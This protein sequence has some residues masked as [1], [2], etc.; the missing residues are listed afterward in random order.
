[1]SK[2]EDEFDN[3]IAE[4]KKALNDGGKIALKCLL[5]EIELHNYSVDDI[6]SVIKNELSGED[7]TAEKYEAEAKADHFSEEQ[8]NHE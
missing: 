4:H 5:K 6:K 8:F 7:M 2:F 1:M 3:L